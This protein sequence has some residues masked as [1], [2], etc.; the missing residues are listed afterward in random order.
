MIG[1]IRDAN[2]EKIKLRKLKLKQ[3]TEKLGNRHIQSESYNL[4]CEV[5]DSCNDHIFNYYNNCRP[6]GKFSASFWL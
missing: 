5:Q 1:K 2:P 3:E 4:R 6:M